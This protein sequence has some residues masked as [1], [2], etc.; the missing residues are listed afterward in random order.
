MFG[1]PTLNEQILH[2]L[3]NKLVRPV[4]K[5]TGDQVEKNLNTYNYLMGKDQA[6]NF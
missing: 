4:L 5:S 3:E 1:E 2:V 6:V